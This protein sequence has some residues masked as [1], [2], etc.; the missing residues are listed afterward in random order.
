M[1]LAA[2]APQASPVAPTEAPA[3]Q[4]TEAPAVQPTEAPAV[5]EV[6]TEAP[7]AGEKKVVTLIWTQE[8]DT[9]NPLYTNMWFVT[10]LF[11]VYMC[12]AWWYDEEN[13]PVPNLVTEIPST[14]N[15]G[16][17]EDGRTI[18]LK[19]RD[20]IVWSDGT[21][22]TS[23][24]FKF[25]YDMELA[26]GNAVASRSPY[27]LIESLET[28]DERTVVATFPDPY[29]PWLSSLFSGSAG[30]SI[31]PAQ[32]LQPVFEAEGTIDNA[33]WNLAP[34]VGCGPFVFDEWQSGSFARFVAN[35]NFWLGRPKL[36]EL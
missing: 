20:D 2:C 5:T 16:I 30:I 28:P 12:Q 31:I 8:F 26:D 17:S 21:P 9:L 33:D 23:A 22:I 35:D 7:P 27:D 11:P 25:T 24:D 10:V 1:L 4:P 18:T 36:D 13:N 15:G 3:V 32:I 6:P 29:A 19:L 34:T 14:E